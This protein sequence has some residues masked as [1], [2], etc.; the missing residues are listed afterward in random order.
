MVEHKATLELSIVIYEFYGSMLG[1]LLQGLVLNRER[2][3]VVMT[4][5]LGGVGMSDQ[6]V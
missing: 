5:G 2:L 6:D 1:A 4:S 3:A